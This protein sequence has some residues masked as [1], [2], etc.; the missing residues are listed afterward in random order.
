MLTDY[1]GSAGTNVTLEATENGTGGDKQCVS[2]T[3]GLFYADTI[4]QILQT[5]FDSRLW[6]DFRNGASDLTDPD[7]AFYGWRTNSDGSFL[8]DGGIVYGLGGV[9]SAYPTYY[10]AKLIPYFA[11][12]GDT[13]V[14]ATSDYPLLAVYSVIRTNGALTLLVINKSSSSN[15]TAA[16]NLSGYLPY[17][18]ATIY[19]YG[20]PQDTAAETGVGSPDIAQTNISGVQSSFSVTFAP[21]SASVMV[22]SAANEPPFTP[23]GLTASSSNAAILLTWNVAAGAK[24]YMIGRSTITG[25]PYT[26]IATGVTATNYLDTG[27]INGTTY[28]YVV[29]A[30]NAYGVSSISAQAGATP[31]MEFTGTVIGSPGSWDNLG[32]TISNVFDGN[33][34]T[35][36]D[37]ADGTGD[38]AGLDLGSGAAAVVMQIEYCPRATFAY[39]MV[40]GQFQG[41]NVSN[42]SSGVVTLF[43]V[44]STPP[45]GVMTVQA[46]TNAATFRY[47]RYIGPTNGWCNVAEVEFRGF[48]AVPPSAPAGLAAVAGDGNVA[49]SW[50][51]SATATNYHIKCSLTSGSG[52][53]IV[54][55]NASLAFTNSGLNDGTLYYFVVSALNAYGESANSA[56]V[57]AR[58]TSFVPTHL[59]FVTADNQLQLNWPA[60]HTGWQL[61]SQTNSLGTNWVNV[62]G[63]G[64]T[65]QVLLPLNAADGA[66][67][68][69][70][71]LDVQNTLY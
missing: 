70:L 25:G 37:A 68:F 34:N 22:L 54:A 17:T 14:S 30:T 69:R 8:V 29:A 65:N 53:A 11:G 20:I 49:L 57:S 36:Y 67:F 61:Q 9:G 3:G 41:A 13:V 23:T 26:D 19:S 5:E 28:Y 47:L 1:L 38:W 55:T 46:V 33:T 10:V 15:L 18:N 45:D 44:A 21:F 50:S 58:P 40:G 60:N 56:E 2:L 7:P 42:F 66:V 71:V 59:G 63:S 16:I 39:R 64:Q 24:S 62:A 43:T 35:Y 6:W 12:D 4:G 52:Y 31:M 32:N 27:L 51:A 48:N